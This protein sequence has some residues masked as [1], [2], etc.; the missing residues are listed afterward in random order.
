MMSNKILFFA[1]SARTE[2]FNK[3]LAKQAY[4]LAVSKGA[5]AT[6][7]DLRDY[8]MP[9]YDGDY[10]AEHS[11]P[12]NAIKLKKLFVEHAG[13]FI[14]SPEYNSS[15][16]PLLKN[17]L[18]WISRPHEP[19]EISLVAFA[20]KHAALAA[21]SRGYFGG[22]RGLVPLR[23]M[24]GNIK[25]TVLPDQL[26]VPNYDK[27]FDQGILVDEGALKNLHNV[28]DKLIFAVRK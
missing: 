27:A 17:S 3:K 21:T 15:I 18:D 12:E 26:A 9:I 25:V 6:F 2:S 16:S 24:L 19:N 1:G 11:L 22:L 23:M 8:P 7:I 20:G 4:E 14:A 28:V 13:L 5:D 10:E